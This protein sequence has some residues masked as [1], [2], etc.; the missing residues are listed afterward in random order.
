MRVCT[1]DD[2]HPGGSPRLTD[3]RGFGGL[4]RTLAGLALCIAWASGAAADETKAGSGPLHASCRWISGPAPNPQLLVEIEIN[5][6]DRIV[7]STYKNAD[8]SQL[9]GTDLTVLAGETVHGKVTRTED[10][11][12]IE[13]VYVGEQTAVWS[14]SGTFVFGKR[15]SS[16]DPAPWFRQR[17]HYLNFSSGEYVE[18]ILTF[19]SGSPQPA[20]FI[21][22]HCN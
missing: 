5:P 22:F 12:L 4:L 8:G 1:S 3:S 11:S 19:P 7:R 18:Q 20:D 2:L 21:I 16:P 13:S 14:I 15:F 6:A 9:F 17:V 10:D